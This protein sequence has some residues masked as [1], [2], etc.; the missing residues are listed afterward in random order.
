[1]PSSSASSYPEPPPPKKHKTSYSSYTEPPLRTSD[2]QP[3]RYFSPAG[4]PSS[5]SSNSRPISSRP[6]PNSFPPPTYHARGPTSHAPTSTSSN[7]TPGF[8]SHLNAFLKALHPSLTSLSSPLYDSGIDSV[9]TL[10]SFC[11]FETT[12][13]DSYFRSLQTR[14]LSVGQ[15]VSLEH[16]N[17][18]QTKL[19]EGQSEGFA[20]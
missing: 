10:G 6:T 20:I 2:A 3:S 17:L 12:I 13:L 16:W 5:G 18:L 4:I 11:N 7:T 19:E 1:M 9:E 15:E 8:D 14:A